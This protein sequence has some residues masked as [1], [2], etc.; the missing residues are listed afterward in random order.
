[1]PNVKIVG[2]QEDSKHRDFKSIANEIEIGLDSLNKGVYF[3]IVTTQENEQ[4]TN[5]FI[6]K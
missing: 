5:K 4:F 3:F 1:V 2:R 6:I